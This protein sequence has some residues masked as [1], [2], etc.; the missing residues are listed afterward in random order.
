MATDTDLSA[1]ICVCS[2]EDNQNR[3]AN[4]NEAVGWISLQKC[5]F[6]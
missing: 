2:S 4:D 6:A 1:E 5:V 3:K